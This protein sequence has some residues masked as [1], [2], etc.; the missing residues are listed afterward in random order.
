M[1]TKNSVTEFILAFFIITG[2]IN[3]LEGTLGMLFLPDMRFG[4]DAFFSPPLFGFFTALSGIVTKSHRELSVAQ[5][6]FREF[7][8]LI[9]IEI[10]VFGLNALSGNTFEP[11]LNIALAFA[12]AVVFVI[13]YF[14]I[15]LNDRQ[16][17]RLFNE[18]L[19]EFQKEMAK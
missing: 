8:Q 7:L 5:I 10:M 15:W 16:S 1:K 18:K 11:K 6:R 3:I 13:V 14:V 9:I 17:A 12:I 2:C 19:K 4:F